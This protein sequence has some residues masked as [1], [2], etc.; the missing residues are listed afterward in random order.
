ML[1]DSGLQCL[2]LVA[3]LHQVPVEPAALQ[4]R[5]GPGG[6]GCPVQALLRAARALGFRAKRLQ[7]CDLGGLRPVL[8][9]IARARDGSFCVLAGISSGQS[10]ATR[11]LIQR[12]GEGGPATMGREQFDALWSGEL[13]LLTPRRSLLEGSTHRFNL[14]WFL[15]SLAKYR[16]LFGE[17]VV[18]SFFLQLFALVT[19]LFFQ[20]V[21]DKVLVHKGFTT[22]D[23]LAF[24]FAVVVAF[25]AVVG[26]LRNYL[27]SH[28]SNRVD[29]ELGARLFNHLANL[30]LAYFEARQVGQ[31]VAR[32]REL[33]T[34]RNFIT[35]TALTLLIDLS[36]TCVFFAV[37][38][39][40]SPL[41]TWV[42][43]GSLPFYIALSLVITPVLRHRLDQKFRDGAANQ[44]FLTETVTGIQTVK[45][46]AVEPQMQRRWED[47][48]ASYVTSSFRAQNVNNI[49]NQLAGLVSKI[50][51]LLIIWW[52]A[53]LV[54]GGALTVG[55]LVAFNMIAARVTA[56]ILKLVQ[57]WQDF[58]QAGISLQRLGDILNA[59]TERG[60]RCNPG[61]PARLKGAVSFE[62]VRFRYRPDGPPVLDGLDLA[63]EPGQV[64]GLVGRSGSGKS[65]LARLLQRL[66]VPE[67]GR[68]LLD[69]TDLAMLDIAWLRRSIGVVQQESFLFNRSVRDNIALAN[70]ALPLERIVQC[71][72]AAGAH[73][74]ILE[75]EQGYDTLIGEQGGN[76]SG[77]QRQRIAIARA[78][79]T[80]PRILVFDEATSALDYESERV[81]QDNMGAIARNRTVFII[82]HRL[83]TVRSCDR[84]AVLDRGRIVESGTHEELLAG[85]GYYA[86]LYGYQSHA[87]AIR[88][89][90]PAGVGGHPAS[91]RGGRP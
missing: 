54:I 90:V 78:L 18:A 83:S 21:M 14:H 71:A 84:I 85:A 60:N 13:L 75:L 51:T 33:E 24:G 73:G 44:A 80:N 16:R 87:P 52:G 39:Y 17:V 25:E 30:P 4:H 41:L 23:V 40:Y 35:G 57:L 72:Q 89:L 45:T 29:V 79:V 47:Q 58:Q 19:P 55:Q 8:P 12:P 74:F 11:F 31:T 43:L 32:V 91:G 9:A 28:T 6:G 88:A 59:P 77:G 10:G 70:P 5:F 46:Q 65:T 15:P 49:A 69:G 1:I 68:V 63:V 50:T 56:P 66:Y 36:F 7:G 42:V 2:A 62:G 48:L 37:L 27:F 86:S 67:A 22:L 64:I 38:W 61:A 81:V 3:Q 20:V 76:L 26:G 82:A 34:L 53:H